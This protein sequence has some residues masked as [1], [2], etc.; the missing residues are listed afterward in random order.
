MNSEP[1]DKTRADFEAHAKRNGLCIDRAPC[2]RGVSEKYWSAQT[3]H[4]WE[5]WKAACDQQSSQGASNV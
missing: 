1:Q 4:T 2:Q 5:G 3:Q